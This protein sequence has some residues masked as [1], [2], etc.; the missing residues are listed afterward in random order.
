MTNVVPFD[1]LELA[2]ALRDE[3]HFSQEQAEGVAKVLAR[4]LIA[5]LATKADV[6]T[7]RVALKDDIDRLRVETQIN[8]NRVAEETKANFEK[9]QIETTAE[10]ERV[11]ADIEWMRAEILKWMF[12]SVLALAGL[13]FG[14]VFTFVRLLGH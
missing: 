5:D 8:F 3:A 9:S 10:I 12:G 1:T 6:E 11:R 4:V 2:R 7:S 14:A 13:F